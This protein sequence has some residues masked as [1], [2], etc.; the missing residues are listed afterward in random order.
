MRKMREA[1]GLQPAVL[2]T[3]AVDPVGDAVGCLPSNK[4]HPGWCCNGASVPH[5]FGKFTGQPPLVVV[6]REY[7][8]GVGPGFGS[9]RPGSPRPEAAARDHDSVVDDSD[10]LAAERLRK[11]GQIPPGECGPHVS[12]RHRPRKGSG[13][14]C[15]CS[16]TTQL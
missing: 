15:Q 8:Y 7:V 10:E 3:Q 11:V 2:E 1:F 14:E 9:S 16:P 4:Q 5:G 6:A 13:Q 12:S